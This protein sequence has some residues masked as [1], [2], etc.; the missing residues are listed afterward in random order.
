MVTASD[1]DRSPVILVWDL[2]QYQ[3]PTKVLTGHNGGVWSLN[4]SEQDTSLLLSSGKDNVVNC[5]DIRKGE[6]ISQVEISS[7]LVHDAQWSTSH[8]SLVCTASLGKVKVHALHDPTCNVSCVDTDLNSSSEFGVSITPTQIKPDF[9]KPPKWMKRSVGVSMGFGGKLVSFSPPK[10]NSPHNVSIQTVITEQEFLDESR[11][12]RDAL[13]TPEN[14]LEFCN[15]K[16]ENSQNEND[17]EIWSYLSAHFQNDPS[18][19]F[20]SKLGY[21]KQSIHQL[22]NQYKENQKE[23]PVEEEIKNDTPVEEEKSVEEVPNKD[24]QQEPLE[25]QEEKKGDDVST[26]FGDSDNN[27]FQFNIEEK[28]T[29]DPIQRIIESSP[30]IF[31]QEKKELLFDEKNEDSTD[32]IISK[33]IIA[34][35]FR[36]AV[37]ICISSGKWADALLLSQELDNLSQGEELY[38][39]TKSRYLH[40]RSRSSYLKIASSIAEGSLQNL[41]AVTDIQQWKSLLAIILANRQFTSSQNFLNNISSLAQ[42]LVHNQNLHA[43]AL[44]YLIS[45]NITEASKLWSYDSAPASLH[46]LIEKICIFQMAIEK[47]NPNPPLIDNIRSQKLNQYSLVIA[48]QGDIGLASFFLG[49]VNNPEYMD[50]E[51]RSLCLKF[52]SPQTT[53]KSS[54]QFQFNPTKQTPTY[55]QPNFQQPSFQQPTHQQPSFQ[56][57]NT[58]FQSNPLNNFSTQTNKSTQTNNMVFYNPSEFVNKPS[59]TPSSPSQFVNNQSNPIVPTSNPPS[60]QPKLNFFDPNVNPKIDAPNLNN[61]INEPQPEKIEAPKKEASQQALQII[62]NLEYVLN[63]FDF[64]NKKNDLSKKLNFLFEKLRDANLDQE[65]ESQL[66]QLSIAIRD[67]NFQ[68]ADGIN[69]SIMKK[70]EN[71]EILGSAVMALKHLLQQIKKN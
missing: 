55:Q 71:W 9:S 51:L 11:N 54:N 53:Q 47:E 25:K 46:Q 16:I 24:E 37:E 1:D 36:E 14:A 2:R 15:K 64:G 40:F 23:T 58:N 3:F 60:N 5:W 52:N 42:K 39:Y 22:L 28:K 29:E 18:S 56:Q 63:T 30:P 67:K 66:L 49:I 61:S 4:W 7:N 21:D 27:T 70:T 32:L 65:L 48:S 38:N 34:G 50:N 6:I 57:P 35:S 26:L 19:I 17:K 43:A 20:L 33:L 41:I 62:Q 59:N 44:C 69:K 45:S 31:T 10:P 12:L 8:A 68:V 13:K